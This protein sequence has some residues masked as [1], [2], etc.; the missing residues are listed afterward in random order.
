MASPT[1]LLQGFFAIDLMLSFKISMSYLAEFFADGIYTY[2]SIPDPIPIVISGN[3][4]KKQI[5]INFYVFIDQRIRR[6]QFSTDFYAMV[7]DK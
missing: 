5:V 6:I 3:D 7:S 4:P 2:S 1:C